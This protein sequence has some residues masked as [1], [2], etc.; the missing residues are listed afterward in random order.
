MLSDRVWF[1]EI[2]ARSKKVF[3]GKQVRSERRKEPHRSADF[4][5]TSNS[6]VGTWK[7][8]VFP[9]WK[10]WKDP[11]NA[12]IL[13][14]SRLIVNQGCTKMKWNTWFQMWSTIFGIGSKCDSVYSFYVQLAIMKLD[15][16]ESRL[17]AS[18]FN[19]GEYLD[20]FKLKVY[21]SCV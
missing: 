10:I 7:N 17:T 6:A 18:D 5:S 8:S 21:Q 14:R 3:A 13:S 1:L 19:K 11:S 15:L 20:S 2:K 9:Q 12:T 4:S 16:G